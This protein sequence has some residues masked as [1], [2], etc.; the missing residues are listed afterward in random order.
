MTFE[1]LM[2]DGLLGTKLIEKYTS[3]ETVSI[4]FVYFLLCIF[5]CAAIGYLI[6]SLNFGVIISKFYGADIRTKGSGNAGATNMMRVYGK[7]ASIMT[8]VGDILKTI[9][10]VFIGRLLIMG[11]IGAYITGLFVI[12]GHAWPL[13]FGFRGGKGVAAIAAFVLST[14][15]LIFLIEL[16]IFIAILFSFKMVSLA[17][18]MIALIYPYILAV[19]TGNGTHIMVAF[20][21]SVL[22]IFLHRQNIVRIFNH[23][24][25]KFKLGKKEKK[26]EPAI[27]ESEAPEQIEEAQNEEGKE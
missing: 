5:A 13:Y 20:I 18:V 3:G 17:S 16:V 23:T 11:V 10:A 8:F 9:I 12:S 2:N 19:L 21:A 25:H 26:Q 22:V 4:P 24:E 6:G 1:K 27:Q 7:K 15:P 14:E